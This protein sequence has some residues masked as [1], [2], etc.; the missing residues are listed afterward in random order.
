M[1][2]FILE[3]GIANEDQIQEKTDNIKAEIEEAFTYAKNSPFPDIEVM[4][5]HIY[6]D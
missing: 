6:K 1:G 2:K 4:N 5:Q 3:K